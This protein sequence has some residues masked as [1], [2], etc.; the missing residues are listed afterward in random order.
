MGDNESE[1]MKGLLGR[2]LVSITDTLSRASQRRDAEIRRRTALQKSSAPAFQSRLSSPTNPSLTSDTECGASDSGESMVFSGRQ[3][4]PDLKGFHGFNLDLPQSTNILGWIRS[5]PPRVHGPLTD[6]IPGN[7]SP[8]TSLHEG[9][10]PDGNDP[11]KMLAS[12]DRPTPVTDALNEA[13]STQVEAQPHDALSATSAH[14]S[15]SPQSVHADLDQTARSTDLPM[16]RSE[17]DVHPEGMLADFDRVSLIEQDTIR[18]ELHEADPKRLLTILD[19]DH[20]T[21]TSIGTPPAK[22][23]SHPAFT[24]G[25]ALVRLPKPVPVVRLPPRC[26]TTE[27]SQPLQMSE[28]WQARLT[29]L[30][31]KPSFTQP[32]QSAITGRAVVIEDP[33]A[34]LEKLTANTSTI[35]HEP[36]NSD[37]NSI[38]VLCSRLTDILAPAFDEEVSDN[39]STDVELR[40]IPNN[41]ADNPGV[42][43]AV[44]PYII[45]LQLERAGCNWEYVKGWT[46]YLFSSGF[47]GHAAQRQKQKVVNQASAE[48]DQVI[49]HTLQEEKKYSGAVETARL[50]CRL[51]VSNVAADAVAEDLEEFFCQYRFY[52]QEI[53]VLAERDPVK[54]TKLAHVD[55]YTRDAAVRASFMVGHVFGLMLKI[56]L[57][58]EWAI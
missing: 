36:T 4:T 23:K 31:E 37:Q 21:T 49:K 13:D 53:K 39:E 40:S 20:S 45:A 25:P 48:L 19:G 32:K 9:Y 41:D 2:Q 7:D 34:I 35:M 28:E 51:I 27:D 10:I 24:K 12:F 44:I 30:L 3:T 16:D 43:K 6:C 18:D 17:T 11:K 42:D 38:D 14:P 5:M 54:R 52:L 47:D 50:P 55:M 22:T 15:N 56:Q 33:K 8:P 29:G 57:A 1:V 58:V 46:T 26:D